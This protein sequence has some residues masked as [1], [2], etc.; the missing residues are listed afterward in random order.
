MANATIIKHDGQRPSEPFSRSKLH[1]S[2]LAACLS[3]RSPVGE[4]ES[5]ASAICVHLTD[6]LGG[7]SEVTSHDV[8]R[9]ASQLLASLHPEAAY[10]YQQHRL[11]I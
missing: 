4:A 11:V 10:L 3:V 9:K 1:A 8:R 6:W 5:I 2:I 7:K